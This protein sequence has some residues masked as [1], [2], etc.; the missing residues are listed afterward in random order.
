MNTLDLL[1]ERTKLTPI[2]DCYYINMT[3]EIAEFL[4]QK[5][6]KKTEI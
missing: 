3:R 4:L 2:Y 6:K 5:N 1:R